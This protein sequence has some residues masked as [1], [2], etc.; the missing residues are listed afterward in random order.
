MTDNNSDADVYMTRHSARADSDCEDHEPL[1]GYARDDTHLSKNGEQATVELTDRLQNIEIS[2]IVSSPF[3]RCIQTVTPIARSKNI[4]IKVEPGMCEVLN[5]SFP[6]GFH[7]AQQL[8]ADGFPVDVKYEPVM[9]RDKL[10]RE[11]GDGVA[12]D[13]SKKVATLL[14]QRLRDGAILFCGHGASCLGIA[15]AF[16]GSGYVGYSSLSHF[17]RDDKSGKWNAITMGDVTHLSGDLKRQS[18]DSAW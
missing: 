9:S 17:R 13:R 6:P 11:F 3:V 14:R 7:D 12:A 1:P 5:Y 18:L 2:H 16:G 10:Q 15:N 8:L 4:K